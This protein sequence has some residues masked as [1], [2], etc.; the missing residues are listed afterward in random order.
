MSDLDYL[1]FELEDSCSEES[2]DDSVM[3]MPLSPPPPPALRSVQQQPRD[4][5][6]DST[7]TRPGPSTA[8]TAQMSQ[9]QPRAWRSEVPAQSSP[10]P[11][12]RASTGPAV[13]HHDRIHPLIRKGVVAAAP[14]S[15]QPSK[16]SLPFR[17]HEQQINDPPS[18]L[19]RAPSSQQRPPPTATSTNNHSLESNNNAPRNIVQPQT[20]RPQALRAVDPN[21]EKGSESASKV[22]VSALKPLKSTS[23]FTP[24]D[25]SGHCAF[26]SQFQ[27]E[28]VNAVTDSVG[29]LRSHNLIIPLDDAKIEE[30]EHQ[31]RQHNDVDPTKD[32]AATQKLERLSYQVADLKQAVVNQHH[33]FRSEAEMLLNGLRQ[34]N[35]IVSQKKEASPNNIAVTANSMQFRPFGGGN[36]SH[37]RQSMDFQGN[38][39]SGREPASSNGAPA[40]DSHE[41]EHMQE[42][43]KDAFLQQLLQRQQILKG[44]NNTQVDRNSGVS[45]TAGHHQQQSM[46]HH[47]PE[48]ERTSNGHVESSPQG[49]RHSNSQLRSDELQ[50]QVSTLTEQRRNQLSQIRQLSEENAQLQK[51]LRQ[52]Q[53]ETTAL[54]RQLE[55]NVE[56]NRELQD[57]SQANA[58]AATAARLEIQK[59]QEAMARMNSQVSFDVNVIDGGFE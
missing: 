13:P 2:S 49:S 22:N 4:A 32:A 16:S 56:S 9:S 37:S 14:T 11:K 17:R 48:R 53:E 18:Q 36:E 15:E 46:T 12:Y 52:T 35:E 21:A 40:H 10:L 51:A 33:E 59:L 58:H 30:D 7:A 28:A 26:P 19:G 50:A 20:S 31:K 24:I 41:N 55:N 47:S 8:Q 38:L 43:E 23:F 57:G 3:G 27:L 5:G 42:N 25:E 39:G 34:A 29:E 1:S 54:R 45:N 6:Q 44:G